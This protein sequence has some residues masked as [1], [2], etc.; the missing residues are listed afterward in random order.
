MKKKL[1]IL[2]NYENFFAGKY[3]G[4][5]ESHTHGSMDIYSLKELFSQKGFDVEL[6]EFSQ[7]D[8]NRD[9]EETY[10]I[11]A[12]S[13]DEG[14]FYKEYIEDILCYL[15]KKGA[16]L[17]PEFNYFRAHNNKSYQE[18]LR[19]QF[20]DEQLKHPCAYS[21]GHYDE[22]RYFKD[23]IA[24]PVVIK[25]SNG[26]GSKGVLL[27]NDWNELDRTCRKFMTHTY[28]D[29]SKSIFTRFNL[30]CRKVGR[31]LLKRRKG[32]VP[33]RDY[34]RTNK[35][36]LEEYI[37]GLKGDYKVLFFNGKYFVLNRLN[38]DNDF[39]ASGSGKFIFPKDVKEITG[40]LNLALKAA[41]EI[42]T[43]LLSLDIGSNCDGC[44]LIEFQSV[45]FGPY[46]LQYAPMYLTN[47]DGN[48]KEHPGS[49]D[50]EEEYVEAIAKFINKK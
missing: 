30:L 15:K 10:V 37:S 41:S 32:V 6:A 20:S 49:F 26:S 28:F 34:L 44:Y 22:L 17:I 47:E 42:G 25:V 3:F 39:R 21:I 18:M 48:W 1:L 29:F 8:F 11:Y 14:L 46:T 2:H 19:Q 5:L 33:L 24:Y 38:R 36:I 35:V 4:T 31:N 12:S 9:Y 27:A 45:Y 43:P 40:V 23:R 7:I 16:I 50:L 13:E